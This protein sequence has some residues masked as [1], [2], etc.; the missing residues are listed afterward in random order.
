MKIEKAAIEQADIIGKVH[1]EAWK[2]T[3]VGVFPESFLREDTASK[4]KQEF[5]E[6]F[7]DKDIFYYIVYEGTVPVGIIKVI[8]EL[9]AYEIASFY[10]LEKY[11]N[12]GYGKQVVVYLKKELHKKRIRLWVLE[13]NTEAIKFYENNSFKFSGNTR[14]I[15]RGQSYI[16]LQYELL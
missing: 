15:N 4:R 1:S 12:K 16:Q 8:E 7:D 11:R 6:S 14:V 2:Q 10:I 5:L 3:Y 13:E 9:D